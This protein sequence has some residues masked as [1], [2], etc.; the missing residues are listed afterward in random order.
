MI[1]RAHRSSGFTAIE[2]LITLFVAAAF[3]V[4]GYQLF[5]VVIKD[6]GD[7]RAES[8]ASNVAYDYMR[9]YADSEATNP[10]TPSVPLS[11]SGVNVEGAADATV[12]IEVSCPQADAPTLSKIEVTVNY[13][14]GPDAH[15]VKY[16][17]YVD[18]SRGATPNTDV[19]NGLIGWWKFNGNA[20]SSAGSS[21]GTAVATASDIGQNGVAANAFRFNNTSSYVRVPSN[22]MPKPSGAFT[23]SGWFKADAIYASAEHVIVSTTQG[24][25][26]SL[27]LSA[28]CS[29]G[30]LKFQAYINGGYVS[31]CT[32]AG[33]IAAN[34]WYF[35]A[36]VYDGSSVKIYLKNNSAVST[37][38]PG[39]MTWSPTATVP[40]CIGSEAGNTDCTDGNYWDGDLDDIRFYN[41]ALS[42]SEVLQLYNGGAK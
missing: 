15:S 32:A 13:G 2:L 34:T 35:A 29:S 7:T 6:G 36:G 41:R 19:T 30:M 10:C 31:T 26:A 28:S 38:A 9:R 27:F 40:F 3:L 18:K 23:I 5:N 21:N 33:S 4:A 24:G 39:A 20:D 8:A 37:T 17:T 12:S 1:P 42:A 14:V 25:G 11:N 22:S 16:A